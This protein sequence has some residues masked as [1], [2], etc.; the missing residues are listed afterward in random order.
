MEEAGICYYTAQ[1]VAAAAAEEVEHIS[2]LDGF[3]MQDHEIDTG[4]GTIA[5]VVAVAAAA[6]M[7]ADLHYK[8]LGQMQ[9]LV[10]YSLEAEG[11][12]QKNALGNSK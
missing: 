12:N 2:Y 11:N 7:V 10:D 5:S 6:Y 4:T 1:L 9:K 3:L 8:P